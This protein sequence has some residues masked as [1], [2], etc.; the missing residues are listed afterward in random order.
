MDIMKGDKVMTLEFKCKTNKDYVAIN[1][2]KITRSCGAKLTVDR[3]TTEYGINN[4]EL[5][6]TWKGC[7]LWALDGYNIFGDEGYYMTD[8]DVEEFKKLCKVAF[9]DFELEDDVDEDYFVKIE[10]VGVCA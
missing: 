2:L 7:Y 8:G 10:S 5:T 3:E 9:F 4:G 1:T 6:M